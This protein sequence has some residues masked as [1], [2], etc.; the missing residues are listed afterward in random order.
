MRV[1]L[2]SSSFLIL[3][4]LVLSTVLQ[5]KYRYHYPLCMEKGKLRL[6]ETLSS[7]SKSWWQESGGPGIWI[8]VVWSQSLVSYPQIMFSPPW[9]WPGN[10]HRRGRSIQTEGTVFQMCDDTLI[11]GGNA[12]DEVQ[13]WQHGLKVKFTKLH[14]SLLVDD[15]K[16]QA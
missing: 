10:E 7:L 14:Y 13:K 1:V 6:L 2:S 9:N 3:T 12:E 15:L 4:H 8:E 11:L 16:Y 5:Y